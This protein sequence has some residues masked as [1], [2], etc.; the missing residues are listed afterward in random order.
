MRIEDN[1]ENE[2]NMFA[3]DYTSD[4]VGCVPHYSKL[5]LA[6]TSFLPVDFKPKRIL[7][8]GCGN[9]NV[10]CKLLQL[11]P[12][13]NF[14]ILDASQEMINLCKSRFITSKIKFVKSYFK[15]FKF[16]DDYYDMITAGFS[17]HHCDSE[18]KKSLFKTIY[19]SLKKGGIFSFS[20]LMINKNSPEHSRLLKEWGDFVNEN[21]PDNEK[22]N[23][24]ME[25]YNEF[26]KPDDFNDQIQWLKEAGFTIINLPFKKNYWIHIQA[27]KS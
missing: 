25:H 14:I 5:I 10:T 15:D 27:I 9:G 16:V 22:W 24:L 26:D 1:I 21:F 18:E 12:D 11:F 2:F 19:S 7:D 4:M 20:D 6:F 23:W 3:K 8:L 13:S 17:L